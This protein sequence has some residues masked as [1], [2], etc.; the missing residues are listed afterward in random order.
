MKT[1]LFEIVRDDMSYVYNDGGRAA[2]GFKGKTGDC[3]CRSIAIATGIPYQKVYDRL[4]EIA[5]SYER[6]GKRKRKK[7]DARTGVYKQTFRRY[8]Q[9]IG[10]RWVPTMQIGSGC[11]V[12]LDANELPKGRLVVSVSRHLTAVIDGVIHDT[13]DPRRD[14]HCVEPD[15][16]GELK[17]GQWRNENGICSIQRRC[18]YGYFEPGSAVAEFYK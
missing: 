12:H 2:A 10:W 18:V 16:G 3:V 17:R 15:H 9:E 14:V 1:G 8:M 6:T 11:T 13:H 7:S 4:N 5:A